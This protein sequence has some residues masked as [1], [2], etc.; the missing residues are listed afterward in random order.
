[1]FWKKKVE[2]NSSNLD[3]ILYYIGEENY[4]KAYTIAEELSEEERDEIIAQCNFSEG[5][6]KGKLDAWNVTI[7]LEILVITMVLTDNPKLGNS[8]FDW[9]FVIGAVLMMLSQLF[10]RFMCKL[11]GKESGSYET[12]KCIIERVEARKNKRKIQKK[13][14]SV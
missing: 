2:P 13:V 10:S 7:P 12:A 5:V 1:M 4:K 6:V 9:C 8:F 11:Y 3:R 14:E